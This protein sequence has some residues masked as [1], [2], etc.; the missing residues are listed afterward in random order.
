MIRKLLPILALAPLAALEVAPV[1]LLQDGDRVVFVGDSITG[2]SVN[3]GPAG[4]H[5]VIRRALDAARPGN[6][7]ELVSLGGSGQGVGSWQNIERGSRDKETVLDVPKVD[8]RATFAAPVGVLVIMLG[9]NDSLAPYFGP[10]PAGVEAWAASYRTLIT[11]LR[12]RAR[13]RVTALGTV[14]PNTEDPASPK[15]RMLALLNRRLAGLAQELGCVLL[16]SGEAV[17]EVLAEGRTCR[18]DFHVTYDYVHPERAGHAAIAW[19]M[20]AGLGERDAAE[21]VRRV[22]IEP[23]LTAARGELPALSYGLRPT[24]P[25]GGEAA[26]IALDWHW[27]PAAGATA[28]PVASL[29]T[30]AGWSVAPAAAASTGGTLTASG[31]LN[32]LVNRLKLRVAAGAAQRERAIAIPAP[33]LVGHGFANPGVWEHGSWK[34]QP[35]RGRLAGEEELMR[36]AGFGATPAGWKGESPVWT[37]LLASVDHTGGAGPGSV[38]LFAVDFAGS[39]AGAYGARWIRSGRERPVKLVLGNATFAGQVGVQVVLNGEP[40]YAGVIT[41]EP[42]KRAERAATLRAGWNA[43]VFKTNHVN[44]QWQFSLDLEGGQAGEL[45]DLEVSTVPR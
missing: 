43:L 34:F 8:V 13:P 1:P 24:L 23:L 31:P 4:Y 33:W 22:E 45:D 32:R 17:R 41:A 26:E 18:P 42:K 2:L 39:M 6:R 20:L 44:W 16:P 37:R 30:P 27:S 25:P 10:D 7:I 11:A 21:A 40:V 38:S 15:N 28:A 3:Y 12:E 36:G 35:E 29:E 9:M 19:G 5:G 14:T